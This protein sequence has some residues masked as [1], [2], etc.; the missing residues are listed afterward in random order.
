MASIINEEKLINDNIGVFEKRMKTAS[1]RFIDHTQTYV[2][3]FHISNPDSTVDDGFL[4][5]ESLVG[6][7][8]PF[9]YDQI[10]HF[11]IYG[12]EAITPQLQ[13]NEWGL[14]SEAEG[15][16]IILPST[17][18]PLE[19]DFFIIEH[20]SRPFV[21]RVTEISYDNIRPDNY[22]QIHYRLEYID[23]ERISQLKSKVCETFDC[24]MEKIG[25]EEQCI[26]RSS[27]KVIIDKIKSM[28]TDIVETYLHLFYSDQHNSLLCYTEGGKMLYDQYMSYFV[29]EHHL[30]EIPNSI[31]TYV[32]TDQFCDH[33]FQ[34]KY[35]RSF[36]RMIE[37]QDISLLNQFP[38]NLFVA[39]ANPNSTFHY[40]FDHSTVSVELLPEY[41]GVTTL[42]ERY[43]LTDEVIN[44]IQNKEFGSSPQMDLIIKYLHKDPLT[45][46]D[47][48]LD[49]HRELLLLDR[50]E[51]VY[52]FTPVIL[53][54]IK[55]VLKTV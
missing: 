12:L 55:E 48:D 20:L 21:F 30:L 49:M 29:N 4:D 47:I 34:I 14:D 36:Y 16:A 32:L 25:T 45:I 3:Y 37:R 38:F 42:G 44:R 10:S 6:A 9:R 31:K 54:I 24:V 40:Y 1:V 18:K 33:R 53:Y 51:E 7:R 19:N 46:R 26:I 27:D 43:L 23:D 22:Y 35:E 13:D 52:W 5:I 11:P 2:T 17:I 15:D 39:G 41:R 8:S 50:N 28:Y